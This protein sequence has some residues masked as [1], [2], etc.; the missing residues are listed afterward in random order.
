[1]WS[2]VKGIKSHNITYKEESRHVYTNVC[3]ISKDA[4][5][6]LMAQIERTL[7]EQRTVN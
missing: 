6:V 1:M 2:E 3:E 5:G 4:S 7:R